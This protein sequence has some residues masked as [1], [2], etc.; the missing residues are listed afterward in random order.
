MEQFW[1]IASYI[2]LVFAAIVTTALVVVYGFAQWEKTQV[3]RQFML[4]KASLA[5]IL[6]YWAISVVFISPRTTYT[7]T[8]PIRTIICLVVGIV[9]LRWLIIILRLR[10]E[11]RRKKHPVW[12]A[13]EAPPP[14]RSER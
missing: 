3:G 5:L 8:M 10:E 4:T 13:P 11:R 1:I 2:S 14:I 7:S 12:D 9:M 6:D